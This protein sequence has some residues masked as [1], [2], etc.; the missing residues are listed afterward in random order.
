MRLQEPTPL[1]QPKPKAPKELQNKGGE[2]AAALSE[3]EVAMAR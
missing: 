3:L 2:L 1:V